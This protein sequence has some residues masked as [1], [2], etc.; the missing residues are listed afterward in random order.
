MVLVKP[1]VP[2]VGDAI[3]GRSRYAETYEFL[4]HAFVQCS[5]GFPT[6]V[7]FLR[8]HHQPSVQT[9]EI[10]HVVPGCWTPDNSNARQTA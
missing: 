4:E 6:P 2:R 9:P 3:G 10:T 8:V 5:F 1:C 7:V